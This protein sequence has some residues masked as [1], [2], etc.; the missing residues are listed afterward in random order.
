[1]VVRVSGLIV[2]LLGVWG[3]RRDESGWGFSEWN[4]TKNIHKQFWNL[5]DMK[6]I[7]MLGIVRHEEI[8]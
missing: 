1:M 3:R 7:H 5:L 8:K 6:N 4:L 2:L